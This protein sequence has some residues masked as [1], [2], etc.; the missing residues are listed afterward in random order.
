MAI[1]REEGND[2]ME[3]DLLEWLDSAYDRI[4]QAKRDNL[5]VICFHPRELDALEAAIPLVLGQ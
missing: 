2:R 4:K 5:K 1:L 3:E